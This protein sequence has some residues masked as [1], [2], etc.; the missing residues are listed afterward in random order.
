[1]FKKQTNEMQEDGHK[2][3]MEKGW[4]SRGNMIMVTGFRREDTFVDKT[5]KNTGTHQLY[6]IT[7]VEG[8]EIQLQHERYTSSTSYEEDEYEYG[9]IF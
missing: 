2:K 9:Y 5:Y 7:K 4:F 3:V 8:D 1:M 6:K